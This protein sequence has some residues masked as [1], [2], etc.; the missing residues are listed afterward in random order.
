MNK[1][2]EKTVP[3]PELG[4]RGFMKTAMLGLAA[5]SGNQAIAEDLGSRREGKREEARVVGEAREPFSYCLNTSTLRGFD[6]SIAKEAEIAAR[7]GYDSI[8][9]WVRQ[10]DEFVKKGGSLDDL[11]REI[12]DLGLVVPSAIGFFE[13]V[14]D[15]DD[16]RRKGLDEARRSME[17][18]REIG[19]TRIAA[20]PVGAADESG[21]DLGRIADRYRTLLELGD[22]VG[23]VPEVEIWGFSKT[24]SRLGEAALVAIESGH[25]DACILPDVF[26]LYKGGSGLNGVRLL[27]GRSI[28]VFHLNDYPAQ[29]PR[30]RINDSDRVYPG[31]GVA[32]LNDL[33]RDLHAIGFRGHLSLELFNEEYWKLDPRTVALTG[34][35]KMQAVVRN[36]LYPSDDSSEPNPIPTRLRPVL[37]ENTPNARL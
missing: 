6:L 27:S 34:L 16:R 26:H 30:E 15:D 8:E 37:R 10:L 3:R 19:G 35:E 17:L 5:T 9:P 13:W 1:E 23:V 24:L 28:Q 11:S 14:V 18:V 29:P 32:P 7:A 2:R 20:P 25:P 4:R 12:R 31:D 22:Q 33:I 21:L 36:A